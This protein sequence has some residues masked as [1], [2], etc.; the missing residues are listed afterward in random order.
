[1]AEPVYRGAFYLIFLDLDNASI[2][3]SE[4]YAAL[5]MKD[6]LV[7]DHF[8]VLL[9]YHILLK[10]AIPDPSLEHLLYSASQKSTRKWAEIQVKIFLNRKEEPMKIRRTA[11]FEPKVW[12]E[13]R[14]V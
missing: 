9:P 12:A 3:I 11:N 1:M 2:S 5:W 10:L 14:T 7:K 8:L 4:L 6:H 13:M